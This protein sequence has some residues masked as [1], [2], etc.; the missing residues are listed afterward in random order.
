VSHYKGR[1]LALPANIRLVTKIT[2][3]KHSSGLYYKH[4]AIVNYASSGVNKHRAS[5]NDDARVIIYDHHMFIVQDTAYCCPLSVTK[6]KMLYKIG[7]RAALEMW[8]RLKVKK[9]VFLNLT[10][11]FLPHNASGGESNPLS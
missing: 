4:V 11:H 8:I 1:L 5:L 10:S 6:K 2:R 9:E 3:H 7:T